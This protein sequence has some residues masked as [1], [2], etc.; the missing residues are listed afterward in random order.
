V[1]ERKTALSAV[2]AWTIAVLAIAL[3]QPA[4][5]NSPYLETPP[6]EEVVQTPAYRYANMTNEEAYAELDRRKILYSRVKAVPGVRAPVRLTGRLHGVLVRSSLP[7]EERATTMFEILDARLALALDDFALVLARHDIVEVVHYTMYRPN[8][9]SAAEIAQAAASKERSE[10]AKDEAPK[11]KTATAKDQADA[12][13]DRPRAKAKRRA[14]LDAKATK[15]GKASRRGGGDRRKVDETFDIEATDAPAA[16]AKGAPKKAPPK[17]PAKTTS[18]KGA[19]PKPVAKTVA[20]GTRGAGHDDEPHGKWAPPGTRHPAGLAIDVG[21][22]KKRDGT[23]L[24]VGS[25]FRGNIGDRTCGAGAPVA[26][27]AEARELR[28]IVCEA[29]EAGLFTYALTPNY[30]APHSD[31][32]HLEIKP[33]VTWFL[34]H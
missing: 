9:P 12:S 19:T 24:S 14:N 3:P 23:V 20:K 5:A 10:A 2:L 31:H 27:S 11:A 17:A 21:A 4:R 7:P 33:G 29:R 18:K 30:D 26:D 1:L 13:K 28:A 34:Y 6:T 25:H 32:F 15:N 22:L 16:F 8:V